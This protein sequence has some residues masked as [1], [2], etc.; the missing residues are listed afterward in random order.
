MLHVRT[1][2]CT[3]NSTCT[4]SNV[5]SLALCVGVS[6]WSHP[7]LFF[8]CLQTKKSRMKNFQTI[9]VSTRDFF[10]FSNAESA[11]YT[12]MAT[13]LLFHDDM[14][15]PV[16]QIPKCCMLL[17]KINTEM[18]ATSVTSQHFMHGEGGAINHTDKTCSCS[19]STVYISN[20]SHPI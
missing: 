7:R 19:T 20:V 2:T 1:C 11:S 16:I 4:C 3:H 15:P 13:Q 14:I 6:W 8:D 10:F 12:A 5:Y 17:H 9:P 18:W